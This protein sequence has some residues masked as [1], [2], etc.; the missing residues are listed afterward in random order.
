MVIY[1]IIVSIALLLTPWTV[2]AVSHEE[3]LK[4]KR[5]FL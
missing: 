3:L 5:N 1:K 2:K 4:I